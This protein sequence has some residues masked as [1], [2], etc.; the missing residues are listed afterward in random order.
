M[1]RIL[2]PLL[3]L[4]AAMTFA[5]PPRPLPPGYPDRSGNIDLERGFRTPPAGYGEVPLLLVDR[6]H[7]D[8]RTSRLAARHAGPETDQQP[9]DQLL[10]HRYGRHHLRQDIPFEARPLHSG[11]VGAF[12]VV[13]DRGR[14]T[15]YDR[16]PERLYAGRGAGLL[17][18][19]DAGR[20]PDAQRFGTAFR[21]SGTRPRGAFLA[22]LC[23][24]AAFA[25]RLPA[26]CL[27]PDR[28]APVDLLPEM[29][30]DGVEW[31]NPCRGPSWPK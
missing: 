7:A 28:R 8:A 16:Q 25:E 12:R 22:G 1:K 2:I 21:Q 9:A 11:V 15:R 10:P 18:G 31:Q 13:H 6:R 24:A 14:Q 27:G 23:A 5:Q 29:G 26:R 20:R 4:A 30:P 19:R 17:C 3:A